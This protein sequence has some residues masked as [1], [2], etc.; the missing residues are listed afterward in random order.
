VCSWRLSRR[1]WSAY[2]TFEK[3]DRGGGEGEGK[4]MG[5][6]EWNEAGTI[7][8]RLLILGRKGLVYLLNLGANHLGGEGGE[9]C[10]NLEKERVKRT[11]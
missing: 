5:S 2:S 4:G 6:A 3:D 7:V 11:V 9:S 8:F 10:S 1:K